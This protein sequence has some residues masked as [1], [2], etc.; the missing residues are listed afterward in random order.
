MS[1]R[2][3]EIDMDDYIGM[4]ENRR[5]EVEPRGWTIPDAVWDYAMETIEECG[6]DPEHSSP[7]YIVDN[8]AVNGDYGEVSE[9][10]GL[11]DAIS[12]VHRGR[13]MFLYETCDGGKVIDEDEAQS[14]Y[15]D[16]R[17]EWLDNAELDEDAD[18]DEEFKKTYAY[19][20]LCGEIG[21][22]YSL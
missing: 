12:D 6:V 11:L 7:S 3:V 9:Y 22:C 13:A 1:K 18:E 19:K 2:T 16:A 20:E 10:G 4:L 5:Q 8:L 14:R 17:D 15:E 21:V